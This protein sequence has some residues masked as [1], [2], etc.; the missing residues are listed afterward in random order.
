MILKVFIYY[1]LAV[2]NHLPVLN[3][4]RLLLDG[5]TTPFEVGDSIKYT[6]DAGYMADLRNPQINCTNEFG[7]A[8]WTSTDNACK[9]K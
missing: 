4:G 2:C 7:V 9:S 5:K 8:N 1:Y 3:H 6:C